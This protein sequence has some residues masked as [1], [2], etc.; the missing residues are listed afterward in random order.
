[1]LT[2]LCRDDGIAIGHLIE[3]LHNVRTSKLILMVCKRIFCSKL[4]NMC[5]P[6]IMVL[7]RKL[8]IDALQYLL[9]ISDYARINL[10]VLVNLRRINV[11]LYNF[12]LC[13]EL[14]C[15]ACD[16]V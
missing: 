3:L 15:I 10:D 13:G 1:M 9:D 4:L 14:L 5:N 6:L 11:K 8:G 12:C 2:Y 16:T 7:L